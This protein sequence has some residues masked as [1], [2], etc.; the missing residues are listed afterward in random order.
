MKRIIFA[1]S[2]LFC[3]LLIY[4]QKECREIGNTIKVTNISVDSLRNLLD[5][6]Y[7]VV[8]TANYYKI[9]ATSTSEE[10]SKVTPQ[11]IQDLIKKML[12]DMFQET[13]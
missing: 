7:S 9:T 2:L 1:I 12:I 10:I 3:V 5:R 8:D 13:P 11:I 4:S 6:Y